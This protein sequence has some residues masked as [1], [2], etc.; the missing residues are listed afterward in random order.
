MGNAWLAQSNY[1]TD[2]AGHGT[3]SWDSSI[4]SWVN[5]AEQRDQAK[6][7]QLPKAVIDAA[8]KRLGHEDQ[9]SQTIRDLCDR[10]QKIKL[11]IKEVTLYQMWA[12]AE[13]NRGM[14]V[15]TTK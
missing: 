5:A 4:K 2:A 11:A 15:H 12:Y 14:T 8:V 6:G 9:L 10:L 13:L 3:G 1:L 7:K